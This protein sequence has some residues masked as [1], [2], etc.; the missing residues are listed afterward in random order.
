MTL[1]VV[2]GRVVVELAGLLGEWVKK[3][4]LGDGSIPYDVKDG[5]SA[6]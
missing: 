6:G 5:V 1:I 2:A 4:G 3:V